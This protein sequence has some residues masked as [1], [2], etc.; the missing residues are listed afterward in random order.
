MPIRFVCGECGLWEPFEGRCAVDGNALE[1]TDDPLV[2]T[3]LGAYRLVRVVGQGGMGVVYAA[4]HPSSGSRVAIKLIAERFA[5]DKDL[6]GRFFAEARAVNL[7]RHENIVNIVDLVELPDGRP[8]IVME[9]ITGRTLRQLA[10]A[11]SPMGGIVH[12]MIEVLAGLAAAH[13]IG[14]VHRDLKP[15]NI[16]VTT[17]GHAK[18][19]DF[20]IAKLSQPLPNAPSMRTQTGVVLGTPEYMAPEM[21]VGDTVDGRADL[22][23]IGLILYELLAGRRPFVGGTDF[24]VMRAQ[25]Q[26]PVIPPREWRPE[27][28]EALE[29]I[30]M[31]ALAKRP[32]DRFENAAAMGKALRRVAVAIG[33]G[34]WKPMLG[35]W[36][37]PAAMT[38]SIVTSAPA[39]VRAKRRSQEPKTAPAPQKKQR[40]VH[41]VVPVVVGVA[42][43]IAVLIAMREDAPP[44]PTTPVAVV[45]AHDASLADA[46]IATD[47]S[48]DAAPVDARAVLVEQPVIHKPATRTE[49][50][51]AAEETVPIDP[52]EP[53][54]A[55]LR[56]AQN[57]ANRKLRD[58]WLVQLR[59][60]IVDP[61]GRLEYS[62]GA[63]FELEY[64]G[65]A[66]DMTCRARVIVQ[67]DD[68][69]GLGSGGAED[70]DRPPVRIPRCSLA[71]VREKLHAQKPELA[72]RDVPID[73][74]DNR[75][76]VRGTLIPDDCKAA[77]RTEP[78]IATYDARRFDWRAYLGAAKQRAKTIA[79]DAKLVEIVL[80]PVAEDGTID[81]TSGGPTQYRFR[82]HARTQAGTGCT[83]T[84]TVSTTV[85]VKTEQVGCMTPL[86]TDPTCTISQVLE[87][88]K[89]REPLLRFQ[90]GRW[91]VGKEQVEDN[92]P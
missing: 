75:W 60:P 6:L 92:C 8:F 55:K 81:L 90:S 24:D 57:V 26:Q 61:Q 13:A 9:L 71:A 35:A 54:R 7:I 67:V 83:I 48:T 22:Y 52:S 62:G 79:A 10:Q 74:R 3:D 87:R 70:C 4:V 28:P 65:A 45:V 88:T 43:G 12:V 37:P 59:F 76:S 64:R 16:L 5:K 27:I 51:P 19:L 47:A 25:V 82:S 30:V 41:L 56:Q 17:N 40:R 44:S 42:A 68:R 91:L 33:D 21:V 58:S 53:W 38:D 11:Q 20:G 85:D 15:D 32:G 34:Q 46:A 80:S 29:R 49:P 66:D 84:V 36:L 18:L 39:T 50:L 86:T 14:I 69:F 73:Y 63:L 1:P 77:S 2:G 72:S 23:A 31:R 89:A 78:V